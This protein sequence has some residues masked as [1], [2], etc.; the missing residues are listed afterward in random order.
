MGSSANG[1]RE[2]PGHSKTRAESRLYSTE[3]APMD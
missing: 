1:K 3:S 2:R